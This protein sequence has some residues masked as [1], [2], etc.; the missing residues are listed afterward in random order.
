MKAIIL[1]IDSGIGGA[2]GDALAGRGDCVVGTTRRR[3]RESETIFYLDLDDPNSTD[4]GWPKADVA[5]FCA[6]MT[7]FADCRIQPERAR[8]VNVSTPLAIAARLVEHGT[9]IVFLSTSA[10]FDCRAPRMKADRP[11]APS[12]AYGRL[13]AEAEAALLALGPS[14]SVL[15]L[16][17]V[18]TP[19]MR[20]FGGWIKALTRGESI[21]AFSDL[22]FCPITPDHVVKAL[23]AIAD[24]QQGGILQV[25][26]A[27]DI[28]YADAALYIAGQLGVP[29]RLV[30]VCS[31]V[32]HGIPSEDLTAYTSLDTDRL[33]ALCG[34]VPP[35]PWSM[36]DAAIA[37]LMA[38]ARQPARSA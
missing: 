38:S 19:D 32:D 35:E 2:L 13:K 17:K 25:S 29:D 10:V 21:R 37:P 8:R 33:A 3:E 31:A 18:L 1:G 14:A 28:S 11:R 20:L 5:F 22:R 34:F 4:A 12:S 7:R 27:S 26:G 24:H 30:T 6:A 23:L 16:T 9:R 15:R 36:I